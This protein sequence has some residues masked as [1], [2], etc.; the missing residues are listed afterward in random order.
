MCEILF[1]FFSFIW[2]DHNGTI[3]MMD[4]E[5]ADAAFEC[6]FQGIQTPRA[7]DNAV[8][9]S[10]VSGFNNGGPGTVRVLPNKVIGDL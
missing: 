2:N 7:D 10:A 3:G 5:V 9:V 4:H 6:P 8:D 1:L